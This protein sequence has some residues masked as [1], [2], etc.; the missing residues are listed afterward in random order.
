VYLCTADAD[1]MMVSFIQSNY[2]GPLLG[3]GSGIVVPGTGIFGNAGGT[4]PG[5][6]NDVGSGWLAGVGIG[7]QIGRGFRTD[8]AYTYRGGYHL[9]D[10]DQGSPPAALY[11]RWN[12]RF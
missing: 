7:A 1:G 2:T 6:L 12:G 5:M 3:F 9:S 11:G 10:T 4:V 8:V